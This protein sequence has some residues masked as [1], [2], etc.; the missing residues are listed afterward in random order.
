MS[1]KS[2]RID[3]RGSPVRSRPLCTAAFTCAM[4]CA[5][6]G[7]G[8]SMSIETFMGPLYQHEAWYMWHKRYARNGGLS[9]GPLG[10]DGIFFW[11]RSKRS[12][13]ANF[14]E[15]RDLRA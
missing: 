14:H 3:G 7:N 9:V 5:K 8:S 12:F 4:S 1:T 6:G 13:S 11:A 2:W 15:E 10:A